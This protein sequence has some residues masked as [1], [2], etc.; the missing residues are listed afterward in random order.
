MGY[1]GSKM[2]ILGLKRTF[3]GVYKLLETNRDFSGP[4]MDIH[5]KFCFYSETKN[6]KKGRLW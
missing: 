5:S 6:I 1:F 3:Y 4:K 2:W